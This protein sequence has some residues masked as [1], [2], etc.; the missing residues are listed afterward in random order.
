[1]QGSD[2]SVAFDYQLPAAPLLAPWHELH[3]RR[4]DL[5]RN[6]SVSIVVSKFTIYRHSRRSPFRKHCSAG[7]PVKTHSFLGLCFLHIPLGVVFFSSFLSLLCS[8]WR[9]ENTWALGR[10]FFFF[11]FCWTRWALFMNIDREIRSSVFPPL[12]PR[13]RRE[14]Q[15]RKKR[16]IY[17]AQ[18]FGSPVHQKAILFASMWRFFIAVFF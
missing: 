1:M 12:Q 11:F 7:T 18:H 10:R 8:Y 4:S 9:G 15:G 14:E 6:V 5:H 16:G 3:I 13:R 2:Q 17:F